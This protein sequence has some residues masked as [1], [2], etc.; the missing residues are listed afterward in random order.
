MKPITPQLEAA[1]KRLD[2]MRA[3]GIP[4]GWANPKPPPNDAKPI[5]KRPYK[6][7]TEPPIG[8]KI[9]VSRIPF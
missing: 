7:A 8:E 9:D 1:R 2:A 4:K 6:D 5:H 3:A